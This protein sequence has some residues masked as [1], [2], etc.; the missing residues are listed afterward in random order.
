MLQ[1]TT[2]K[3]IRDYPNIP[4]PKPAVHST[5]KTTSTTIQI[6]S[7]FIMPPCIL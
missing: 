6:S 1:K 7:F 5:E 4:I 3:N 2:L